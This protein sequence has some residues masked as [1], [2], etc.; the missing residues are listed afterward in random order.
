MQNLNVLAEQCRVIA[1]NVGQ[2]GRNV[3][4]VYLIQNN[5]ILVVLLAV[6]AN[7]TSSNQHTGFGLQTHV[8]LADG[9]VRI[10]SVVLVGVSVIAPYNGLSVD[11]VVD[12]LC[13]VLT[14]ASGSE[15]SV[16]VLQQAVLVCQCVGAGCP[17]STYQTSLVSI[18]TQG[19]Q[20]HLS[21]FLSGYLVVRAEL[22]VALTSN[23][24][25]RLAV[26]DVAACPV[27]ANVGERGLVVIV[28]RSVRVTGAQNVDHLRHLRTGYGT[29]RLER[30]VVVAI[31]YAQRY[32]S[33]HNF[34]VNLDVSR[35]RE[36]RTSEH[37]ERASERQH[38]CEN[39][40]EIR[41]KI[42]KLWYNS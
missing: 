17:V 33:V 14:R 11:C 34:G 42:L 1:G 4:L 15:G 2:S 6:Q 16:Y 26:L 18:V 38:Q 22:G 41:A 13:S 25:Q 8:L 35:I 23:D 30:A 21:C 29:V 24:A 12:Q 39:L 7:L 40:F 37:S 10:T 20:Q 3:I 31:Y 36:R 5:L 19:Y 27:G 9:L 32:Q 28:R